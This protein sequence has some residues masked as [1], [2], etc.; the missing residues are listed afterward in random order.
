MTEILDEM[1]VAMSA[2]VPSPAVRDSPRGR[3]QCRAPSRMAARGGALGARP[4]A[5]PS[6]REGARGREARRVRGA[7]SAHS[8]ATGATGVPVPPTNGSGIADSRK[9]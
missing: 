3:G 9:V 2:S 4:D 8:T 7:A 5:P 1:W 6:G